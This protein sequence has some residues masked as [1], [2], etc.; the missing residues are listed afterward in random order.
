[1]PQLFVLFLLILAYYFLLCPVLY[2]RVGR[3]HASYHRD[4]INRGMRPYYASR[5]KNSVT[6]D[7]YIVY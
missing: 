3:D 2:E 5:I 6:A 4:R 1:M 7:L